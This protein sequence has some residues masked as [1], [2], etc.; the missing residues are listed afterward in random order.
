MIYQDIEEICKSQVDALKGRI[1]AIEE[2]LVEKQEAIKDEGS[3]RRGAE[4]REE[5]KKLHNYRRKLH[6]DIYRLE[7]ETFKFL[8][9]K[10]YGLEGNLKFEKAYS[11]AY[12]HGHSSGFSE[13]ENYFMDLVELIS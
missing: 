13:I 8:L 9:K 1:I 10:E 11:V 12:E 3:K 4:L 7:E 2:Q 6:D 5:I